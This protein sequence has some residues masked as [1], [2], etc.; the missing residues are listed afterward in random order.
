MGWGT[1][2]GVLFAPTRP[3]TLSVAFVPLT[4]TD[5]YSQ[6]VEKESK[7]SAVSLVSAG[8][9]AFVV[10]SLICLFVKLRLEKRESKKRKGLFYSR[11]VRE[12][13]VGHKRRS[14]RRHPNTGDDE[15][16]RRLSL[17]FGQTTGE[18]VES[19]SGEDWTK[20]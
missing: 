16:E 4:L 7:Q 13:G 9:A 15:R 8:F 5:H 1:E 3:V 10:G 19:D 18:H 11:S 12:A 20:K 17:D 14:T 2:L 6:W